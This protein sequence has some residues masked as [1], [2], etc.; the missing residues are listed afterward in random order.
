MSGK[1][2]INVKPGFG[3]Y[4]LVILP[5]VSLIA[6][7]VV[8]SSPVYGHTFSQ[9]EN[10]LF[11]TKM[12]QVNSQLKFI[13]NLLPSNVSSN[14]NSQNVTQVALVHAREAAGL[15]KVK[16]PVNNLT[17]TQEIAERNPRIT[18]DLVRGFNDLTVSLNLETS[19]KNNPNATSTNTGSQSIQDKIFNLSG[20]VNE[21]VS[22]RVAKDIINNS[23]NQALILSNLGNEI[24][25]SYGQALGF[26]YPKLANMVSTMNMSAMSGASMSMMTHENGVM[27]GMANKNMNTNGNKM[28]NMTNKPNIVNQTEYQN[29]LAY[30]KQAQEIVSKYLKSPSP[31][32]K[33]SSANVQSQLNKILSQLQSTIN[34]KGSFDS[35]MNLVHVQLH[36][37]LISNYG[38]KLGTSTSK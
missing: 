22:A 16:D 8:M 7:A 32:V 34:S 20:L 33:T 28:Q 9:N 26:P 12:D 36:P 35:V 6:L 24:F 37:T 30:V 17:W 23:T 27:Q 13:Q 11:L 31:T 2:V 1:F 5:L 29:A 10:S 21:A 18:T 19:P 4:T 15:L 38:L 25:Y 3:Y 14:N